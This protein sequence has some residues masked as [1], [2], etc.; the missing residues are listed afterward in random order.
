MRFKIVVFEED[1]YQRHRIYNGLINRL[2]ADHDRVA[3][4]ILSTKLTL[5]DDCSVKLSQRIS[6]EFAQ[7]SESSPTKQNKNMLLFTEFP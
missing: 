2:K 7:S 6:R 4:L 3:T 1:K 5:S